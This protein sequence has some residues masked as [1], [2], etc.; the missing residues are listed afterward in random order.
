M[1]TVSTCFYNT[2]YVL[3][4]Y[5][6]G[7]IRLVQKR[8]CFAC[9]KITTWF[10][11]G[12]MD[13]AAQPRKFTKKVR[14][15]I[16]MIFT[17]IL[18]SLLIGATIWF[19]YRD[20]SPL[21]DNIRSSVAFTLCYPNALPKGYV[22]Q[23][24][25]VRTES[26]IIFYTIANDK[27]I[28]SISQQAKGVSPPLLTTL[29]F[30]KLDDVPVGEAVIATNDAS[31]KAIILT[32]TSILTINGSKGTPQDVIAMIAKNMASLPD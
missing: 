31:P 13:D 30:T 15:K 19:L 7:T 18:A 24:Q 5:A 1:K 2:F 23:K 20:T 11:L 27:H 3:I 10:T 4:I 29:G 21:P 16:I 14:R 6:I 32:G 17:G 22:L 25:S 9:T 12:H 28:V 26:G 8:L